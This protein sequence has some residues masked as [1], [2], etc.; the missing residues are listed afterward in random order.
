MLTRDKRP[1]HNTTN[2]T[3]TTT[4]KNPIKHTNIRSARSYSTADKNTSSYTAT[5]TTTQNHLYHAH[6]S[7]ANRCLCPQ[8]PG[9]YLYY[10]YVCLCPA[11]QTIHNIHYTPFA[12]HYSPPAFPDFLTHTPQQHFF[13]YIHTNHPCKTSQPTQ[14]NHSITTIPQCK[15]NTKSQQTNITHLF[16]PHSR[17]TPRNYT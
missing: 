15:P 7:T 5:P 13:I 12:T 1:L 10:V 3:N 11:Q 9:N 8:Q 4:H 16:A 2:N 6:V 17:K 14:P